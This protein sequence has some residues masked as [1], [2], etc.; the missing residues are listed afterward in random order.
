MKLASD[1]VPGDLVLVNGKWRRVTRNVPLGE[2]EWI[3]G[4]P[5]KAPGHRIFLRKRGTEPSQFDVLS[6]SALTTRVPTP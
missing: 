5:Y 1:V 3:G 6:S 4:R 2:V